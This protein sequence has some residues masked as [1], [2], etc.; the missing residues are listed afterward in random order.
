[1][2]LPGRIVLGTETKWDV[3]GVAVSGWLS[4]P[5][6]V[7]VTA[8]VASAPLEMMG[9]ALALAGLRAVLPDT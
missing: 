6:P 5:E 9:E 8:A 3:V 2:V 7:P 4:V 1:M